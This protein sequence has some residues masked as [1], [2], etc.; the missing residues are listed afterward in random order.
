MELESRKALR[1]FAC[2][3]FIC[4]FW[5]GIFYSPVYLRQEAGFVLHL[6]ALT[7]SA[8]PRIVVDLV[9]VGFSIRNVIWSVKY[10][11]VLL[12]DCDTKGSRTVLLFKLTRKTS[13]L[14]VGR[15]RTYVWKTCKVL[16]HR[17]LAILARSGRP[18][19]WPKFQMSFLTFG[20]CPKLWVSRVNYIL[21]VW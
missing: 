18:I 11:S 3:S 14:P 13:G 1:L 10:S 20:Y 16:H 7:F 8:Y 19:L 2:S 15:Y 17:W 6:T 9:I 5:I 12:S 4:L 21:F